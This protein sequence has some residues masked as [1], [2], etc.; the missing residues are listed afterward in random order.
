MD[1]SIPAGAALLLDFISQRESNGKY[2]TIYGN[3]QL[4]LATPV[5]ELNLASLIAKQKMWGNMWGSSAAGRYQFMPATLTGLIK[6]MGLSGADVFTPDLQDRLAYQ[7]LLRRG[8]KAF[9][10]GTMD[11]STFGKQL[12]EEWAS[13]P[14]LADTVGAKGPVRRGQSYYEGDTLNHAGVLPSA[15]EATL[16]QVQATK[17][18]PGWVEPQSVH[19]SKPVHPAV[20]AGGAVVI[21]AGGVVAHQMGFNLPMVVIVCVAL[22]I[23]IAVGYAVLKGKTKWF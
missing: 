20:P 14:V 2:D 16:T 5:T 15:V 21:A 17:L 8:Y 23:V 4:S 12:A 3:H 1:K 22:A 9:M 7:L 13:L 18:Q 6:D 19:P 10:A 11:M